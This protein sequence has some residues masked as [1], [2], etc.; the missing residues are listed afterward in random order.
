M[1]LAE[2]MRRLQS[3]GPRRILV[4]DGKKGAYL[5]DG[6]RLYFVG[7]SDVEPKGTAG[8]GDAFVSTLSACLAQGWEPAS[9]LQ[10][11]TLNSA[12]VVQ[13]VDTQTGLLTGE[14]LEKALVECEL[15]SGV[16]DCPALDEPANSTESR[17]G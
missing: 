9:A 1:G 5:L 12:S 17:L 2:V 8:A 6:D 15:A 11:S 16:W 3:I 10:A 14:E 13:H 7:S 4:T